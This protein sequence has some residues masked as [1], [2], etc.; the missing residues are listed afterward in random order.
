MPA[1]KCSNRLGW[2]EVPVLP[3]VTFF[4]LTPSVPPRKKQEAQRQLRTCPQ[5]DTALSWLCLPAVPTTEVTPSKIQ[6]ALEA[7]HNY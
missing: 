3:K 7:Y 1:A 5:P 4:L 2:A 6:Y